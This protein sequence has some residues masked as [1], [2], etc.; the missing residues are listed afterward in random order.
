MPY[1]RKGS[2]VSIFLHGPT[3]FGTGSVSWRAKTQEREILIMLSYFSMHIC[4]YS[5]NYGKMLI[6]RLATTVAAYL[7]CPVGFK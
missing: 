3:Y 2:S 6:H 4:I 1:M 5:C 7:A